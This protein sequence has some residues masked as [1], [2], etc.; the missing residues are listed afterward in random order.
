MTR[1]SRRSKS[2]RKSRFAPRRDLDLRDRHPALARVI[3]EAFTLCAPPP[4]LKVSEWADRYRILS[5]ETSAEPGQWRTD[6]VPYMREIMDAFNDPAVREIVVE[7]GT[8]VAYTEALLNII[9]YCIDVEPCPILWLLPDQKAV[10]EISKNRLTPMLRDTPC[11]QGKVKPPRSRDSANTIAAKQFPG[12]RLNLVGSHAPSDLAS[13]PIRIVVED[14]ND[15]FAI[16]AGVEGDPSSLVA[17]RQAWFHNRKTIKGSS[18]TV[19]GRSKIDRDYQASDKRQCWVPCPHCGERQVLRWSNVKWDKIKDAA[20][21]TVEHRPDTAA[22]QCEHCGVLWDDADRWIA[23][24]RPEWRATAPFRGIAGFHLPQFYSPVVTLAGMV[25]EFLTAYGRL[26]GTH[27]DV[28]KQIAFVNTVLAETWEEQGESVDASLLTN[29][30][31]QYGPFDLPDGVLFATAGV[32]VQ[33]NRL[34]LQVLG[35]GFGEECWAARYV[36]IDGDPAQG[37]VWAD[38]DRLLLE[39]LQTVSGRVVRIRATAIDTGGH[40]GNQVHQFCRKR[41]ARRVHAIKGANGPRVIWPQQASRTKVAG[42]FVRVIGVDTAKDAIYGRLKI[43]PRAEGE[44]A[45]GY[46]H[47]P[48][49]GEDGSFGPEYFSQLTAEQAV[50]RYQ[51]GKPYRVWDLPAGKRNEALDTFVYALAARLSLPIRL[52]QPGVTPRPRVGDDDEPPPKSIEPSPIRSPAPTDARPPP[53]PPRAAAPIMKPATGLS[54]MARLA[55]MQKR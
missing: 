30:G 21:K 10:E 15:R 22:Y 18:P 55:M 33:A 53:A 11:L 24:R 23:I 45:P 44:P 5:P 25:T 2:S 27:P 36:V 19:K 26:P 31:E 12:G 40:H 48:V 42:Q 49:P 41:M 16:S 29:R 7:K 28:T 50:T 39:P 13:R 9:G 38:L 3:A 4:D 46:V 35:W 32:D 14:E 8:Q 47:F 17:K 51:L 54:R 6:R 1:S 43:R 20:G 34:E 52:D 37:L